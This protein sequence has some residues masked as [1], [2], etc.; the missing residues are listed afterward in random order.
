MLWLKKKKKKAGSGGPQVEGAQQNWELLYILEEVICILTG[1]FGIMR[2]LKILKY[3]HSDFPD[4]GA[5]ISV[6][7]EDWGHLPRADSGHWDKEKAF[8]IRPGY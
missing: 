6:A 5:L 7:N 1:A 8:C 2:A 4:T 3:C